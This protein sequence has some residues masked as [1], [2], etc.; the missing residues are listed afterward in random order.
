MEKKNLLP[1]EQRERGII[2]IDLSELEAEKTVRKL[3]EIAKKEEHPIKI[4]I[5]GQGSGKVVLMAAIQ[6]SGIV[7]TE[8]FN[9]ND[10]KNLTLNPMA[11][12]KAFAEK[13]ATLSVKEMR[14]L[15]QV[16]KDEYGIMPAT[17]LETTKKNECRR[18]HA[19]SRTE[20]YIPRKVGKA[21]SRPKGKTRK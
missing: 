20:H 15:A 13:L 14:E 17:S 12:L 11:D 3:I 5:A 8:L 7:S 2:I 18:V 10:V 4:G 16:L 6:A 19:H 21:D 9:A 1:P